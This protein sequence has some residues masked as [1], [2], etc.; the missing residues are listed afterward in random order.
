MC[1][2]EKASSSSEKTTIIIIIIIKKHIKSV[3]RRYQRKVYNLRH[4]KVL[5][6]NKQKGNQNVKKNSS[7]I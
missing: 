2:T 6:N 1:F 3:P 5:E 4:W 7:P